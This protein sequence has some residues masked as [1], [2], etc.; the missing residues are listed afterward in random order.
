MRPHEERVVAEE[1]EL[2]FKLNKLGA[3]IHGETFKALAAEDR[4][5]LQEQ[6]GHMRSYLGVLRRRIQR[7]AE[8][9][10]SA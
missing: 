7:F 5:L 3:F 1:N 10:A 8:P 4:T 2:A 6:D 9:E